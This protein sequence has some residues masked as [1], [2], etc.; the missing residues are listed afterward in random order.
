M[1]RVVSFQ[2]EQTVDI[3]KNDPVGMDGIGAHANVKDQCGICPQSSIIAPTHL[4]LLLY[5]WQ[6]SVSSQH[7]FVHVSHCAIATSASHNMKDI[8]TW[9]VTK[10]AAIYHQHPEM[11]L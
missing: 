10:N 6:C 2:Q 11:L 8:I 1:T 3:D 7:L 5:T 4:L 9:T